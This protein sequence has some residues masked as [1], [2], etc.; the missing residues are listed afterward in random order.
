[1]PPATTFATN[2]A[3]VGGTALD[4]SVIVPVLPSWHEHHGT[5]LPVQDAPAD[6][7][8]AILAVP[9]DGAPGS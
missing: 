5:A 8:P 4:T 6:E 3:D 9:A 7:A 1:M 2:G